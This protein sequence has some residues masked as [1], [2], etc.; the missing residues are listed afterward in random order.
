[1]TLL[2]SIDN[3]EI[4]IKSLE[5][6]IN[7]DFD[8]LVVHTWLT[9]R[10]TDWDAKGRA[11]SA[12]LAGRDLK[13]AEIWL[14][15]A[16]VNQLELP[17]VTPLQADFVLASQRARTRRAQWVIAMTAVIIVVL[18]TLAVYAFQQKSIAD[19]N[20]AE[21][22]R[23]AAIA[24][25]NA[26]KERIARDAA[27]EQARIANARRI[28]AQSSAALLKYPQRSLL[29]AVEA[30]WAEQSIHGVR[31]AAAE[32]SLREA[33]SLFG[34]LPI[35][36]SDEGIYAVAISP[37]NHWLVTG[38]WDGTARLWLLQIKDLIDLARIVVGRNLTT[39][40]REGAL[41][42]GREISQDIFGITRPR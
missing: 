28:A 26:D 20:A 30:L 9:Q 34:G 38:S 1:V 39:R 6:A 27:E 33:L 29:L 12:L 24:S 18:G 31:V 2:R 37:N 8:L 10:D 40:E 3:F 42:P 4:G 17:N 13:E 22:K 15:K 25:A 23:Q 19:N 14:P 16:S 32:Q 41:F 36:H 7:T 5:E 11:G 21:A 35:A